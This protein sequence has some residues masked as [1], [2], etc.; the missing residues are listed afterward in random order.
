MV[1]DRAIF[2]MA[3]ELEVG[4]DLLNGDIANITGVFRV[5]ISKNYSMGTKLTA[6]IGR[7]VSCYFYWS[8][9]Q[10]DCSRLFLVM[11]AHIS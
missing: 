1:Q 10:K 4:D 6:T 5:S 8:F 3:D 9:D 7:H 2:A 11:L